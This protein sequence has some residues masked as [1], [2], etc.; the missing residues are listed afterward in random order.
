[1][2]RPGVRSEVERIEKEE[3]FLSNQLLKIR[4]E[5][6]LTQAMLAERMK[7]HPTAVARL[8][9]ALITG[10][11]SPSLDSLQRYIQACGKRLVFQVV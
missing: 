2:L 5:A 8:E 3:F 4:E 1:M 6:G 10:K 9:R 11:P 7:V